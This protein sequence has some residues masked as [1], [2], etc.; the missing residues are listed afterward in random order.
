MPLRSIASSASTRRAIRNM[1]V[2]VAI[3][4]YCAMCSSSS[5]NCSSGTLVRSSATRKC[6]S[7]SCICPDAASMARLT[8]LS[9]CGGMM[10]R[11]HVPAQLMLVTY[12]CQARS[13]SVAFR[14]LPSTHSSPS[15]CLLVFSPAGDIKDFITVVLQVE[16]L[17][18]PTLAL[19]DRDIRLA[20]DLGP[21]FGFHAHQL[22]ELLRGHGCGFGAL[23][24]ERRDEFGRGQHLAD[25]GVERVDDIGRHP[26]RADDAPPG[27]E[28]ETGE[29]RLVQRRHIGQQRR[30]LDAGHRQRVGL[31]GLRELQYLRQAGYVDVDMA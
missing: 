23:I 1:L 19:I 9:C 26:G 27:R 15:T 24:G 12:I 3:P 4:Q 21:A 5:R 11:D 18:P 28:V 6:S 25:L 31:A 22:A 10:L 13:N 7:N 14:A 29:A 8:R 16:R 30:A 17:V 20:R 2:P